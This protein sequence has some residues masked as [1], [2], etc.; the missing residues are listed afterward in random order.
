MNKKLKKAFKE[1]ILRWEKIVDDVTYYARSECALCR[2]AMM[3]ENDYPHACHA[4]PIYKKTRVGMCKETPHEDFVAVKGQTKENAL[5]ELV[6]LKNLYIELI[7]CP[8]PSDELDEI[9]EKKIEMF[10]KWDERLSR[11]YGGKEKRAK[12]EEWVDITKEIKWNVREC[13]KN[14]YILELYAGKV[15]IGHMD[16]R[17]KFCLP[18]D[19]YRAENSCEG[20]Y[21]KVSR[22]RSK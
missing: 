20:Y 8:K 13:G 2:S 18:E 21:L 15:F 1:T 11:L 9:R 22:K 6:F 19:R 17:G 4:C 12:K 16:G 14:R 7:D 3:D 5:R 10:E